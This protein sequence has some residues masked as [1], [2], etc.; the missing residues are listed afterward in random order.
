M[1]K[2]FEVGWACGSEKISG[3]DAGVLCCAVEQSRERGLVCVAGVGCRCRRPRIPSSSQ[4]Q[5]ENVQR[6]PA[7]YPEGET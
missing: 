5:A 3:G 1:G 6:T 2:D 7:I 4:R